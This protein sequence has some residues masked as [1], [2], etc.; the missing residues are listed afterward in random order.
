MVPMYASAVSSLVTAA[1]RAALGAELS[2]QV[3]HPVSASDIRR[4]AIAVYWPEPP[5]ARY[6]SSNE[7]AM[8]A[9]ED[10][11]PFAWSVAERSGG[12]PPSG[13][14]PDHTEKLL[15]IAGPGLANQLNGGL[16]I[17]YGVPMRVGDT[18]T[19]VRTLAGYR[20]RDG[21]L[22]RMLLT[23]TADT[24]TNQNGAFVKRT[25]LTLIRY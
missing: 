11:N 19:A 5:P 20:E 15:G 3:S 9:P 6:L 7:A 16:A 17:T 24:W 8:R 2:R 21:R 10:L 13:N 25:E 18:I 14:D 23:T 1:M 22:G 4:W 12:D